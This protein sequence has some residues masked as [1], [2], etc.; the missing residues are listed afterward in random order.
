MLTEA[1][2]E[3]M[4]E[5]SRKHYLANKEKYA[6]R[7]LKWRLENPERLKICA[8]AWVKANPEKV[9]AK[10]KRFFERHP[11]IQTEYQRRYQKKPHFRL[12]SKAD[13]ANQNAPGTI[14]L[15]HIQR[16]Y[17]EN[18]KQYGTLT[19]YLCKKPIAFL[20]DSLD[21]IMP[22]TRGG[23]NEYSNLGIAHIKCNQEKHNSTPEEYFS[24]KLDKR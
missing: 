14:R 23:V 22:I 9:A 7:A 16:L 1:Q 15:R 5:C 18:I 19:C 4:R 20:Q 21:H 24:R 8:D 11:G 17:E 2:K 13:H 3:K 12:K 10:K 6:A